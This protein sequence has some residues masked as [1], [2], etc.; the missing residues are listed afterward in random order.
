MVVFY[1]FMKKIFLL[2][3]VFFFLT[4]FYPVCSISHCESY[5]NSST[6]FEGQSKIVF[7]SFEN[8]IYNHTFSVNN[9]FHDVDVF[10]VDGKFFPYRLPFH[11]FFFFF[12]FFFLKPFLESDLI[13]I[14]IINSLIASL[15]LFF[16]YE[17]S[18]KIINDKKLAFLSV[19]SSSIKT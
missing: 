17:L 14:K 1:F 3:G 15:S 2:V 9:Y 6:F 8:F 18:K 7:N 10:E 5:L 4:L 16:V 13:I 19:F 11:T 12:F